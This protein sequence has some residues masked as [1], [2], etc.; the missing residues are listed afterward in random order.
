MVRRSK[1]PQ[2]VRKAKADAEYR[3]AR[4]QRLGRSH[5]LCEIRTDGCTNQATQTHH[6]VRRSQGVDHREA[7]L[8][9]VCLTCHTRIHQDVAWAKAAGWIVTSWPQLDSDA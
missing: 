2:A 4:N 7:N 9:S 6:I 8:K 1:T 3:L 5:G